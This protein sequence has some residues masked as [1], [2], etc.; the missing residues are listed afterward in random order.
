MVLKKVN[1]ILQKLQSWRRSFRTNK[2]KKTRRKKEK[3]MITK[4]LITC[5]QSLSHPFILI[6]QVN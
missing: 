6:Q 5:Y 4:I 2:S 3:R 1:K